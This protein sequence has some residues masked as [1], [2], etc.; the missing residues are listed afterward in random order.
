PQAD[1]TQIVSVKS[2]PNEA[3]T[4]VDGAKPLSLAEAIDLALKQASAFK[5]AQI[6]EQIVNEDIRQAKAGFYPKITAQPNLIYTSPS[7]S[8]PADGSRRLPSFLGANAI[9]EFQAL[10]NAAGEIDTSGKLKAMLE[11]S[12][13]LLE[14]A[15]KGSEIARLELVQS[16]TDAY[17]NLA[18]ATTKRRGAEMNLQAAEGFESN[19]KL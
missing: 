14:S 7:F 1:S 18:L 16:A 19:T 8:K 17:F 2:S 9:T 4:N 6:N 11:R 12:R 3:R 15:R 13:A 10:I 5:A